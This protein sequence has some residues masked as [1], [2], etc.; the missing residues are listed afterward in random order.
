M[1]GFA[2]TC[3]KV[4]GVEALVGFQV[5]TAGTSLL[6]LQTH[7]ALLGPRSIS[8]H[9]RGS[10]SK[11]RHP[12]LRDGDPGTGGDKKPDLPWEGISTGHCCELR[13]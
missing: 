12:R 9:P 6:Y 1:L 3:N 4:N 11:K 5:I 10:R 8:S 13:S 2:F 7:G